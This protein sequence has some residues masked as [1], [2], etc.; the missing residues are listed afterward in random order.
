MPRHKMNVVRKNETENSN[1]EIRRSDPGS[2]LILVMKSIDLVMGYE[3]SY[4]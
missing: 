2:D 4:L 3:L 1:F